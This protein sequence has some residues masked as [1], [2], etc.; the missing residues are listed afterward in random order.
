MV[1]MLNLYEAAALS[2]V[3]AG[4][5]VGGIR[6]SLAVVRSAGADV[7][8]GLIWG[9]KVAPRTIEAVDIDP[10]EPALGMHQD[11]M[12]WAFTSETPF[13]DENWSIKSMRKL[14]EVGETL[15]FVARPPDGQTDTY[16]FRLT[17]S[18]LLLLP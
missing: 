6:L 2:R 11:W 7:L 18:T 13:K 16:S 4:T 5:T 15:F 17:A 9:I 12:M 14:E 8:P 1:D 3:T 10:A